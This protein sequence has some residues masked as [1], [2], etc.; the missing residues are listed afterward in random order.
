MQITVI[1]NNPTGGDAVPCPDSTTVKAGES[2]VMTG[3][4]QEEAQLLITNYQ[5]N[6]VIIRTALEAVDR[7]PVVAAMKAA[8]TPT[9]VDTIV[10][11]GYQLESQDGTSQSIQPQMYL[12]CFDDAACEVPAVNAIM[13][14]VAQ[15]TIDE[16]DG[17]NLLKVTPSAT[18]E[19]SVSMDDAVDEVVYV[20]AW[21]VTGD[22]TVD[23]SGVQTVTFSTS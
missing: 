11:V 23:S 2:K 18:G 16:G 6:T 14:T 8:L 5:S 10:G 1:N 22:Y 4:T 19:V 12:G 7:A 9:D 3:R 13:D 20:K 17:T 21:P 15:G